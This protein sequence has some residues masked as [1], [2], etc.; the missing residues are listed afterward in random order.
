MRKWTA[1]EVT[2]NSRNE[3]EV[4][5]HCSE[6]DISSHKIQSYKGDDGKR[7]LRIFP[8]IYLRQEKQDGE[9]VEEGREPRADLGPSIPSIL[10]FTL[11]RQSLKSAD[12]GELY[13]SYVFA[14]SQIVW[15]F[16][17]WFVEAWLLSW[18]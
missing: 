1:I 12:F 8:S 13:L 9:G 3:T 5:C 10:G 2:S 7:G 16:V 14:D 17:I 11:K 15:H 18:C 4:T 6:E